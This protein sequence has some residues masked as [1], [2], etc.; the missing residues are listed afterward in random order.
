MAK[1]SDPH[2]EW[3]P[4]S[5]TFSMLFMLPPDCISFTRKIKLLQ[6]LQTEEASFSPVAFPR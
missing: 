4:V 1:E 2:L 3:F 6:L 5:L